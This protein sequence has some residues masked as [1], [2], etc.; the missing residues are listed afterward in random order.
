MRVNRVGM[1]A[2]LLHAW[3]RNRA[4]IA[5]FA[6]NTMRI[7]SAR[8]QSPGV[9]PG[10]RCCRLPVRHIAVRVFHGAPD[11]FSRWQCQAL[12]G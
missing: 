7:W 2:T 11:S 6:D 8:M 1:S 4:S 3:P 5:A 9:K 12:A 10:K